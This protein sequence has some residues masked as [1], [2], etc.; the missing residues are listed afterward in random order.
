[1]SRPN[2]RNRLHRSILRIVGALNSAHIFGTLVPVEERSTA[3]SRDC[4]TATN[5]QKLT[6]QRRLIRGAERSQAATA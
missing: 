3:S 4:R 5:L 1:M 2:R 6:K